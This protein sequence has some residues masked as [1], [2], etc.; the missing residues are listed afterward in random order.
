MLF[1]LLRT[2]VGMRVLLHLSGAMCGLDGLA[3]VCGGLRLAELCS[4]LSPILS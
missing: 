3:V 2:L 1:G 4:R